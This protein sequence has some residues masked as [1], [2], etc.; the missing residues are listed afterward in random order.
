MQEEKQELNEILLRSI[1]EK[2]KSKKTDVKKDT[3]KQSSEIS[4]MKSK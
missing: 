3:N 4:S 1:A 2:R